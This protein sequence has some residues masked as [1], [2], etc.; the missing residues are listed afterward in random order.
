MLQD[1]INQTADGLLSDLKGKI[2]LDED[3]AKETLNVSKDSLISSLGKEVGSGN[4]DGILNM[5]NAGP[6]AQNTDLFK[7]LMAGL[8]SS[9]ISKLGISPEMASKIGNLVLPMI[10][11][12][13]S[14]SKSGEIGKVDL[15][16]MLGE[17]F[18]GSLMG[19]AGD[20][21]K[22]GLGNLFK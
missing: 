9:Y 5:L 4:I 6:G 8:N 15:M 1:I 19:K 20:L 22:G 2:G 21:L 10:V 12:A 14:G 18:G 16:K 11:S 13:I 17:G 7:N 3:K